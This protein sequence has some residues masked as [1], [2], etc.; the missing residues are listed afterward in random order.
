M[1]LSKQ[2]EFNQSLIKMAV[3]LYQSDSKITLSEQDYLD[4]LIEQLDWDSP[5]CVDAFVN[6][7]IYQTRTA[8]DTGCG[9]SYLRALQADLCYDA[10]LALEVAM[11]ITGAD[12]ER[13]EKETELLSLLTHKILAREL[14][15]AVSVSAKVG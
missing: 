9:A 3:L 10:N 7:V 14:T 6:D 1:E 13:C 2:Q 15:Q 12:G 11:S 4:N 8:L 5:I